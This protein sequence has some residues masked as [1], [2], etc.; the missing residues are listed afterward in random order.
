M[1]DLVLREDA[2]GLSTL[3]LNRPDKMNSLSLELFET[4]AAHIASIASSAE[5]RCVVLRGAGRCFSTG[6]DMAAMTGGEEQARP[7]F[8]SHVVQQFAALPQPVIVA[9]HG[10][11]YTGALELALAGDLIIAAQSAKFGDT[12]A[13]FSLVPIWGMTQ[14]LPRRIGTYKA[15]EMMFTCRTYSGEE[16]AAIGLATACVADADFDAA[17]GALART[18]L[19]QSV[20]SQRAIKQLLLETDGLP[21]PAG[22]AHEFYNS[23]GQGADMIDRVTAFMN[24]QR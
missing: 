24:R 23:P 22:L 3:T 5:V 14:R 8:Q 2:D 7:D 12:H 15:R 18:I 20:H 6:N 10:H 4:L 13:R 1:S 19:A 9:V 11:C 21:L 16:A 17:V